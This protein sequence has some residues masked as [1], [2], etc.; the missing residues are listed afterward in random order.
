MIELEGV[1]FGWP[2]APAAFAGLNCRIGPG[3]K[4]VLLGH[5]G[6]GKST[7]LKL[8]DGLVF[9]TAGR[10]LYDGVELTPRQFRDK[11]W[12]RCFRQEVGLLFQD[13]E[14]MLFNPTVREEIAYGPRQLG[15]PDADARVAHWARELQLEPLL[16]HAPFNLSGGQ[17]QKV[18]LAAVLALEPKVLL[19][20]EPWANLDPRAAGWLMQYLARTQAT[21][22]VSTHNLWLAQALGERCL[23]L[24]DQRGGLLY[25]GPV[26]DALADQ[27]LLASAQLYHPAAGP[28]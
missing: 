23:I 3:E 8:L 4:V 17:K 2:Q 7:L 14:A 22:V 20:D 12:S 24:G 19:L 21:V 10:C 26:A 6:S 28:K 11:A 25:D 9:A 1:A 27:A 16:G 18:A 13:P 15:L 5:N